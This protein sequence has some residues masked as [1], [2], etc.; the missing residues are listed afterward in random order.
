[1]SDSTETWEE[2]LLNTVRESLRCRKKSPLQ[3]ELES[4]GWIWASNYQVY[5]HLT[6]DCH[7]LVPTVAELERTYTSR[8][9]KVRFEEAF[10]NHGDPLPKG[11][12]VAAYVRPG[13][14]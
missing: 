3:I 14:G 11:H 10:D 8:G 12:Y 2:D 7:S 5:N 13:H 9:K 1:M 4:D 6:D